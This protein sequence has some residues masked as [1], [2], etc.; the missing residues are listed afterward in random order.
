ILFGEAPP[1]S[2]LWPEAPPALDALVAQMMAK[3]PAQRPSDGA[4]LAEALAALP[5][6]LHGVGAGAGGA[7]RRPPRAAAGAGGLRGGRGE[8]GGAGREGDAAVRRAIRAYGGRLEQLADG[9]TIVAIEADRQVARD[10]AAQA[11]RCA[12]AMRALA[13][14]RPIA[15][16]M[17]RVESTR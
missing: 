4:R 14:G 1:V 10:L 8:D 6:L 16:A 5:P 11:A 17:G 13:T 12:L 15:I 9:S 7:G 2:A 3:E